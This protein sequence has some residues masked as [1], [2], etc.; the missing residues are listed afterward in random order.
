M[1]TARNLEKQGVKLDYIFLFDTYLHSWVRRTIHDVFHNGCWL[2]KFEI[3]SRNTGSEHVAWSNSGPIA[4]KFSGITQTDATSEAEFG[5]LLA[6]LREKAAE[7]YRG[8]KCALACPTVLFQATRM[9][10][11]RPRNISPDLGWARLLE[12]RLSVVR[13]RCRSLQHGKGTTR[14]LYRRRDQTLCALVV[15]CYAIIPMYR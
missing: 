1:E 4:G 8:P 7:A 10:D 5:F 12:R 13:G 14:E 15:R 3:P 9:V 2:G 6:E 11:G